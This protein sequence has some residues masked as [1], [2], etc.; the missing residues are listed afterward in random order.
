ME[1]VA[2]VT[3]LAVIEYMILGLQVGQARGKYGVEAPAITGHPIFERY[4][5]VH[6][7]TLEQMPV[8]LPGLWLFAYYVSPSIAAALGLVFIA[9]RAIY[10]RGYVTEPRKRETGVIISLIATSVLLLGGLI[11]AVIKMFRG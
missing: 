10:A 4:F 7:N 5:R 9:A 8:F 1:V 3:V 11:G 2:I 6:Q